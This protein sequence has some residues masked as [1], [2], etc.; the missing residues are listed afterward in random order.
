[1]SKIKNKIIVFKNKEKSKYEH[2]DEERKQDILNFPH[3]YRCLL[4]S[5]EPSRGKSNVVLNILLHANKP[6][7]KIYLLHM[8]GELTREYDSIDY[9]LLN[10]LPDPND[11]MFD[12]DTKK[13]LIIEDQDFKMFNKNEL[14]KLSRLYGFTSSHR[15]LSIICSTQDFFSVPVNIRNMQSIYFLWSTRNIDTI[16]QIARRVGLSKKEL[17]SLIQRYLK[18]NY[19][20]NLCI[21]M[22]K[23]SPAKYRLNG[24][25]KIDFEESNNLL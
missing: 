21:D 22:T 20:N 5:N 11:I 25:Q 1:M 13:L 12:N 7:K 17:F 15:Y 14:K 8:G 18:G 10:E 6:F 9:E 16:T 3:P 2:W 23:G 4:C 24:F 19:Y